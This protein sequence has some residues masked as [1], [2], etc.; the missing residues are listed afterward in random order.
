M[1][2]KPYWFEMTGKEINVLI[3]RNRGNPVFYRIRSNL[4]STPG[5]QAREFYQVIFIAKD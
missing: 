5:P 1:A 2:V 3:E 4:V